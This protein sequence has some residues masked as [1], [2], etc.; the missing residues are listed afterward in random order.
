MKNIVLKLCTAMV[1]L[2]YPTLKSAYLY[3]IRDNYYSRLNQT[4]FYLKDYHSKK[5]YKEINWEGEFQVEITYVLPFAYWH[6]LNGTLKSTTSSTNTKEFYFFS[7]NHT[8]KYAERD[9]TFMFKNY[10]IPNMTHSI[11]K[12]FKK[13]AAVPLKKQYTNNLFVFDKPILIIA[14]KYNVEWDQPPINFLDIPTLSKIIDT[15]KDKYQIIYNRPLSNQITIDNSEILDLGEYEWLKENHPDVVLLKDLYEQH[16]A[17]VNNFNHLQLMV[18]ANANHFL[19]MH[20]GT[21][22]LASY[23]GGTNII[24]SNNGMEELFNEYTTIFPALSG[25]RILHA[26]TADDILNFMQQYY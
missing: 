14:N 6:Y 23:F 1:R 3:F 18:Y 25:A 5:K 22:A 9:A 16:K 20:G 10:D 24:L 13:W 2:R 19:S 21:A 17:K 8:E 15:Y 11:S 4:Q 7:E 26:K 12:S